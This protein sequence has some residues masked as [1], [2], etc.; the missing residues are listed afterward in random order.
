MLFRSNKGGEVMSNNKGISYIA[1]PNCGE[2]MPVGGKCDNCGYI[3]P[4]K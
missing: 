2:L 4:S 1:C 3:D